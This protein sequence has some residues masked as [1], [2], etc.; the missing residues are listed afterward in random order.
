VPSPAS[1]PKKGDSPK[2]DSPREEMKRPRNL[3][4]TLVVVT[5][6]VLL[7]MINQRL[8][9]DRPLSAN[10]LQRSLDEGAI[11]ELQLW[12]NELRAEVTL[13]SDSAA[14]S[15]EGDRVR[16]YHFVD[17]E[18][19]RLFKE[20]ALARAKAEREAKRAERPIVRQRPASTF[21]ANL[22][23]YMLPWIILFGILWF[24]LFRQMRGMGQAGGLLSFG[25]S[26][27]NLASAEDIPT[28]FDDVAGIE[29]AKA[30][31]LEVIEFLKFPEKFRRLGGRIPR[32]IL[33]VGQPGCGKTLLAKAIAGEAGVPFL[34]I[35][36]SDFVEMFVG[37]GASRVRDLFKQA[38]E[39]SPCIIFLDEIDAVG[40][41]RGSGLGGGHDEREQT[42]NAILV[43]M[44]GFETDEGV[45]V[46]ASTN[47]PDV[48]DPALL[49]PGR[50]DR[51]VMIDLPDF[52]GRE[53]ILK[54][55]SRRAKLADSVDLGKI[56]R[57]TTS[58]TGAELEALINEA[59]ILAAMLSR[60]A[61]GM[62]ELEEARDKVRWGRQKKSKKIEESDRRVT[63]YHEA[64][65][66]LIAAVLDEVEPLHKVT[67]I[68]RGPSL[69]AT[70][71]LPERDQYHYQRKR[72]LGT[73]TVFYGGRVAEQMF[74]G[75]ISAGASNDIER[76]TD[77][78]RKMVC[79]WGMS[80]AAGAVH[81]GRPDEPIYGGRGPTRAISEQTALLIDKEMRAILD[82]AY[83]EAERLITKQRD[84]VDEIAQSLL[85]YETL[86]GK[87]VD[88]ILAGEEPDAARLH[89][90]KGS[91]AADG[92][93]PKPRVLRVE[94][95]SL[96]EPEPGIQ[97]GL[98]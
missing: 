81:Y 51:Q 11:D 46:L 72:M 98:A 34:S 16:E 97:P 1:S 6:I 52:V 19:M 29:D 62:E 88:Q 39:R 4:M 15:E 53:E 63:A 2:K 38:K 61:I 37:V 70:M 5:G 45:I 54:V 60:D 31:V 79:D 85:L 64:G 10:E 92:E 73:L 69:G 94:P 44:D 7:V 26:R 47:R 86:S 89:R 36:G 78:A 80:S 84:K 74:C 43:E 48:L 59:A 24:F 25:K 55:H 22:I 96:E 91:E 14:V 76:A 28:T 83:K 8:V 90:E 75:D 33:L 87:D 3:L 42:L 35:C 27:A 40:R 71:Q 23:T 20:S 93:P 67:I 18:E 9:Q 12:T 50:F 41:R 49:R 56:A 77:L 21:L 13:A 95:A 57:G 30:E 17:T 82:G 32:G 68:P 58:F 65:H 66:A